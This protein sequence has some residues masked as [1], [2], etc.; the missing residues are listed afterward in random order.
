MLQA[1]SLT[2]LV[3]Y[4]V[5]IPV[6]MGQN[7]GTCITAVLSGIGANKN[8]KRAA[9]VHLYF[10]LIGTALFMTIFYSVNVFANLNF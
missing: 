6:I 9:T 4:G 7:I 3:S 1:L 8:A 5:A 2:G 10:N